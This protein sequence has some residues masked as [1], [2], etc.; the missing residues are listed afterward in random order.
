MIQTPECDISGIHIA[1]CY[2][3]QRIFER[4][5]DE[6]CGFIANPFE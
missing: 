4:L 2:C 1:H 6:W 3:I 5:F